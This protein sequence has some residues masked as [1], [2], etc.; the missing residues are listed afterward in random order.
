M[1]LPFRQHGKPSRI[2]QQTMLGKMKYILMIMVLFVISC[3]END[4]LKTQVDF[5]LI[6]ELGEFTINK[7]TIRIYPENN[8][9]NYRIASAHSGGGP[10]EPCIKPDSGWFI[11][12][13]NDS[14]IWVYYGN[15]TLVLRQ[16]TD[17][18]SGTYQLSEGFDTL[19]IIPPD[20][21]LKKLPIEMADMIGNSRDRLKAK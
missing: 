9:L 3:G 2:N 13:V 21:V 11:Y 20:K 6:S 16:F 8:L 17:E 18:G 14:E 7:I 19:P 12:Y 1:P 15:H 5:R 4:N 10:S